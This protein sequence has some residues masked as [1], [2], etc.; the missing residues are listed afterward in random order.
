MNMVN[1]L[2]DLK[3]EFRGLSDEEDLESGINDDAPDIEDVDE[4]DDDLLDDKRAAEPD[5][6]IANE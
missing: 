5:D 2:E 1:T 6:D 4:D 3:L